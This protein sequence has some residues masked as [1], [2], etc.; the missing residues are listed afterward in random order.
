MK[1]KLENKYGVSLEITQGEAKVYVNGK[2]VTT[3][4]VG[5]LRKR[6]EEM[7]NLLF[8]S[9]KIYLAKI[10]L[11]YENGVKISTENRV[12]FTGNLTESYAF[13]LGLIE[14]QK[15]FYGE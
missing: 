12:I 8:L 13:L 4:S 9:K 10:Q 14:A 2:V 6:L 5:Q 3:C 1:E 7:S 11:V 15:V